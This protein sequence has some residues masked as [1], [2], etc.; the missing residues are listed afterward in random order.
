MQISMYYS[1]LIFTTYLCCQP[2]NFRAAVKPFI[3]GGQSRI[4]NY[5]IHGIRNFYGRIVQIQFNVVIS[6]GVHYL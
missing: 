5:P 4:G 2:L 1:P 6:V 3:D